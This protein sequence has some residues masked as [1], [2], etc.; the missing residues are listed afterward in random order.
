MSLGKMIWR[1][2]VDH[3]LSEVS[4]ARIL[5]TTP[6]FISKIERGDPTA[7]VLGNALVIP[8]LKLVKDNCLPSGFDYYVHELLRSNK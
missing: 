7:T 5:G 1:Y 3:D 6:E 4:I 8:M 2:R